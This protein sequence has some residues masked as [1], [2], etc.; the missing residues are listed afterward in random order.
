MRRRRRSFLSRNL[1]AFICVLPYPCPR[2]YPYLSLSIEKELSFQKWADIHL[3]PP[4]ILVL[5][6]IPRYQSLSLWCVR[7]VWSW[8][9]GWHSFVSLN[10]ITH[11]LSSVFSLPWCGG[12]KASGAF[13]PSNCL[14]FICVFPPYQWQTSAWLGNDRLAFILDA[15]RCFCRSMFL[16]F[17][18]H[19]CPLSMA[20]PCL[21]GQWSIGIDSWWMASPPL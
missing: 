2:P 12:G 9:V 3:C 21:I 6:F 19:L 5:I 1:L 14:A 20:D 11:Y 15:F 10:V 8:L 18:I 4:F 13:L 16:Y 7:V 17:C